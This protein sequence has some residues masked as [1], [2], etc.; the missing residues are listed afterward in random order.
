[1]RVRSGK[2]DFAEGALHAI[3]ARIRDRAETFI[4]QYKERAE[5]RTQKP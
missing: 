1:M 2:Y 4:V 3:E 5:K